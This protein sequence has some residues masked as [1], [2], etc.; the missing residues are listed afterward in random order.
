MDGAK[1]ALLAC[2]CSSFVSSSQS[3][4]CKAIPGKSC[5]NVHGSLTSLICCIAILMI[6]FS[7]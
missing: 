7:T 2:V 3:V 4:L 5:T 1:I 6:M